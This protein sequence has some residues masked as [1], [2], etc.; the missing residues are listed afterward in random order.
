MHWLVCCCAVPFQITRVRARLVCSLYLPK[1]KLLTCTLR[2]MCFLCLYF[3][4]IV[5]GL[6]MIYS[7]QN[8]KEKYVKCGFQE[9][10][11]STTRY[12]IQKCMFAKSKYMHLFLYYGFLVVEKKIRQVGFNQLS[13]VIFTFLGR[14]LWILDVFFSYGFWMW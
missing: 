3:T 4:Q 10:F 9:V 13:C 2:W 11:N 7:C 14:A 8:W 6:D 12:L 1:F 5:K